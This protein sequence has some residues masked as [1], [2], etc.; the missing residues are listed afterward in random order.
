MY[1][2]DHYLLRWQQNIS[3]T[4]TPV[5]I[6]QAYLLKDTVVQLLFTCKNHSNTIRRFTSFRRSAVVSVVRKQSQLLS[7]DCD[8]FEYSI[9][10]PGRPCVRWAAWKSFTMSEIENSRSRRHCLGNMFKEIINP[11]NVRISCV[12]SEV[13]DM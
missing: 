12:L 4:H 6:V 7:H 5:E 8:S 10:P 13:H 9:R 3:K 11:Q 1:V 2:T